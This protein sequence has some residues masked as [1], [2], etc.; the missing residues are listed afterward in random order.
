[1]GLVLFTEHPILHKGIDLVMTDDAVDGDI[2]LVHEFAD[3]F[4]PATELAEGEWLEVAVSGEADPDRAV[5]QSERVATGFGEWST[6]FDAAV[7]AHDIVVSDCFPALCFV[8]GGDFGCARIVFPVLARVG[9]C[10][11][12]DIVWLEQGR[13]SSR[14]FAFLPHFCECLGE[15]GLADRASIVSLL[16]CQDMVSELAGAHACS[17]GFCTE[18]AGPLDRFLDPFPAAGLLCHVP[19]LAF[20]FLK[21]GAPPFSFHSHLFCPSWAKGAPHLPPCSHQ[22]TRQISD[23]MVLSSVSG[24]TPQI[25]PWQWQLLIMSRMMK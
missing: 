7:P 5:V 19:S 14:L 21:V 25:M 10:M 12:H 15:C 1:M 3:E 13:P 9:C 2:V 17:F 23:Y 20:S 22:H 24:R 11:D 8:P 6:L 18:R 4:D 16:V